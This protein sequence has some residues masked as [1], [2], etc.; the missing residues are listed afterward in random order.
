MG[1]EGSASKLFFNAFYQQFDWKGRY[2]RTKSDEI[3]MILDIGYTIL[4]N[5]IECFLRMFGF[6]L[7]KGVFHCQ[8]FKRKSLVCDIMEPF[9]CIIDRVVRTSINKNQFTKK[10]FICVKGEYKLKYDEC[11]KYYQSFFDALIQYKTETFKYVQSYYRCFMRG[12]ISNM[13]FFEL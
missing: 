11:G 3:N 2:P 10:D 7:Y 6:D 12:N 9:R 5:Y 13:F 1:A 8:W 4:F